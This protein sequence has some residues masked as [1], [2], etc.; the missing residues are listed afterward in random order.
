MPVPAAQPFTGPQPVPDHRRLH[1]AEQQQRPGDQPQR[2]EARG[3]D[4]GT[5]QGHPAQQGIAGEGE[6]GQGGEQG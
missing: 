2:G 3:I 4:A 1:R 5:V 6:H